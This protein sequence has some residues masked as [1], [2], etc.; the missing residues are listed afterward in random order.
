MAREKKGDDGVKLP[1]SGKQKRLEWQADHHLDIVDG[2]ALSFVFF[3]F[4]HCGLIL[5]VCSY[6]SGLHFNSKL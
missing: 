3:V 5:R 4:Y 1:G 2:A 6:L